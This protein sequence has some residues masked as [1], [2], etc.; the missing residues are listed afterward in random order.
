MIIVN[1]EEIITFD[2]I[3]LYLKK[4]GVQEKICNAGTILIKPNFCAGSCV[5]ADSHVVTS[6]PF[7]REIVKFLLSLNHKALIYIAESDDRYGFAYLK[8]ENLKLPKIL[9]LNSAE[10]RRVK[11]LDLSRD[12]LTLVQNELFKY[13]NLED[14][15]LWISETL[16]NSD[17]IISLS[18]LKTHT[19]TG[20]SGACKN[21]FGCLPLLEKAV[22]HP[23]IH[24]VIHDL[25][26]AVKPHLNIVDAFYAME[27]NGPVDGVAVNC[28]F[29]IFSEDAVQADIGALNLVGF[30]PIRIKYLKY[31][32]SLNKSY[33]KL[34]FP[35]ITRIKKPSLFVTFMNTIGLV[36]QK[37]GAIIEKL[38]DNLHACTSPIEVIAAIFRPLL[39]RFIGIEK[40]RKIKKSIMAK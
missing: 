28:G 27:K 36:I 35:S 24:K 8:F 11:L 22:Y 26:L 40:L 16:L 14:R 7:L 5:K 34:Y 17:V 21:L 19:N 2:D 12:K 15:Q 29:R 37:F 13:F 6:I 38:G 25:T 4:L 23:N 3:T 33:K 20:Y 18:N 10:F 1:K 39:L 30:K 31:L 9:N 32:I